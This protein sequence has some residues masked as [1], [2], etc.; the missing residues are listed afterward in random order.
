MRLQLY[1][2]ASCSI[3]MHSI[4]ILQNIDINLKIEFG[5]ICT[6]Q[7][8]ILNEKLTKNH[9]YFALLFSLLFNLDFFFF[10]G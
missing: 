2:F 6:V 1:L 5:T 7:M 10:F 9:L 4:L 8:I 3:C